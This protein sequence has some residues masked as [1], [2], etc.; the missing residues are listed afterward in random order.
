MNKVACLPHKHNSK[1]VIQGYSY[2]DRNQYFLFVCFLV[3]CV[4]LLSVVDVVIVLLYRP[5]FI[6]FIGATRVLT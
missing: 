3:C 1:D 6:M 2:L 4:K 5:K